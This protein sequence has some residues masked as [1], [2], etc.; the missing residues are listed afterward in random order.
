[1]HRLLFAGILIA[2][3]AAAQP[4]PFNQFLVRLE[5]VDKNVTLQSLG[6]EGRRIGMEHMAYNNALVRDGKLVIGGQALDEKGMFGI[7]I[8]NA[9]S[10]EA[11]TEIVNADPL[12]KAKVFRGEVMPFRTVFQPAA[13]ERGESRHP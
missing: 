11:A 13:A 7:L 6:E 5:R 12:V 3:S 2:G 10:R 8:L 1:M 4:G 9:A